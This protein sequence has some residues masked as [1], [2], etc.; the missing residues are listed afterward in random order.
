MTVVVGASPLR[1]DPDPIE[2][3][4]TLARALDATLLAV[5]AVP[6]AWPTPIDHGADQEYRA[7]ARELGEEVGR[8]VGELV[9]ARCAG[10]RSSAIWRS[11]RSAS[12]VLIQEAE[13]VDAELLVIGS[14]ETGREGRIRVSS[15]ADRLLHSSPAPLALAPRGYRDAGEAVTRINY[16]FRGDAS[17]GRSLVR[18]AMLSERMGVGLRVFTAAVR[19]RTMYPPEVGTTIE[20]AVLEA[21]VEQAEA[22]QAEAAQLLGRRPGAAEFEVVAGTGWAQVFDRMDW[23]PGDLLV[24]G[25][26]STNPVTRLFLGS[27]GSKIIRYSPVPVIVVR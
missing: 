14:G 2:L 5:S 13:R 11:G 7:L 18:A 26:S 16:A 9:D 17:S 22:A 1:E 19:G 3:G 23:R 6:A 25:S 10:V 20:D 4:A 21:F 8:R 24:V 27:S 12:T 15:T